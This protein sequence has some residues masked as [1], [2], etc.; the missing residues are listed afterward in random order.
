MNMPH[1]KARLRRLGVA[2]IL[3]GLAA[4]D[5]GNLIGPENEPEVN[6]ATDSFQWQ[7]SNLDNVSQILTYTWQNTAAVANVNQATSPSGGSANITIR[8]AEGKQVYSRGLSENGTFQTDS[9]VGG[10]W[11]I[12]VELS[13]ASGTFNFRVQA[14]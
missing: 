6:N 8:D 7:V 3:V 13:S 9:G 5:G 2:A 10:S 14:P 11:T 12:V 4:C 1:F